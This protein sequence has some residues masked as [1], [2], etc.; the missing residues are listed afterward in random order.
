MILSQAVDDVHRFVRGLEVRAGSPHLVNATAAISHDPQGAMQPE[1]QQC[2]GRLTQLKYEM[3]TNKLVTPLDRDDIDAALWHASIAQCGTTWHANTT[4]SQHRHPSRTR[5]VPGGLAAGR[6]LHVPPHHRRAAGQVRRAAPLCSG[7]VAQRCLGGS[8]PVPRAE[9]AVV[10]VLAARHPRHVA[11]STL[12]CA[13][14]HAG[15]AVMRGRT[16]GVR[17]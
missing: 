12:T 3:Q 5:Q 11:V 2:I 14:H 1:A 6:V 13:V 4:R 10:H 17:V 9:A 7:H 8:R 15:R 16:G